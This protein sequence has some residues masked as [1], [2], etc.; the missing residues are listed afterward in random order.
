MEKP[1]Y[2]FCKEFNLGH[3][4]LFFMKMAILLWCHLYL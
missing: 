2:M 4:P 3:I 1:K